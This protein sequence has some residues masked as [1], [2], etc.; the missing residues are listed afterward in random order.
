MLYVYNYLAA[1]IFSSFSDVLTSES[2][3]SH[4]ILCLNIFRSYQF[5][6]HSIDP[7]HQ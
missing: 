2:D 1:S 5:Y 7:F 6:F 4:V 3:E